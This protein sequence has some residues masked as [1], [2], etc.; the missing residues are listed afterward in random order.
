M[1]LRSRE[2]FPHTL[3]KLRCLIDR[4]MR[5]RF[6]LKS[7]R[8]SIR[9]ASYNVGWTL[10]PLSWPITGGG[11]KSP[12]TARTGPLNTRILRTSR[13]R[14]FN[15]DQENRIRQ[16]NASACS[17][18]CPRWQQWIT[19][20]SPKITSLN[21]TSMNGRSDVVNKAPAPLL[22]W[23]ILAQSF[24]LLSHD[25]ELKARHRTSSH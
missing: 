25:L 15:L 10:E 21:A 16:V 19:M 20:S 3:P 13:P 23:P 6:L 18:E 17:A 8:L 7:A 9:R 2:Q 5:W 4:Q 12:Y 24:F 14:P 1:T 22:S 11:V